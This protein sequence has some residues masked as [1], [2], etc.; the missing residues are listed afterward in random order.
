MTCAAD[1]GSPR[2]ITA[3]SF[4]SVSLD[5]PLILWNIAKISTALS[6]FLDAAYFGINVLAVDQ[7]ALAAQFARSDI[8]RFQGID[9]DASRRSVPRLK[10]T[11]AWFECRTRE[12]HDCGDHHIIIGEVCDFDSADRD[13]LLFYGSRFCSLTSD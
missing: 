3:N 1:D 2:G 10:N 7:Q 5:P 13:P 8:D 11:L 6:D 12:V 4:S 9:H